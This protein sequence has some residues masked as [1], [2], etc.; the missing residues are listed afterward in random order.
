[1]EQKVILLKR[2]LE[3]SLSAYPFN[4]QA[5]KEMVKERLEKFKINPK[6]FID[7]I[8]LLHKNGIKTGACNIILKGGIQWYG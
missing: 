1:M 5:V 6:E 3:L 8:V 2:D 4:I 7:E